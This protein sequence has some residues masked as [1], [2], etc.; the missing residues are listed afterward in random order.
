MCVY[1]KDCAAPLLETEGKEHLSSGPLF[2]STDASRILTVAGRNNDQTSF[3]WAYLHQV[4]VLDA[5]KYLWMS[6]PL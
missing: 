5:V 1:G 3:L 6:V 2:F 4:A